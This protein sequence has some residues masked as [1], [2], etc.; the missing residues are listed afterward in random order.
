[1]FLSTLVRR[2]EDLPDKEAVLREA[3]RQLQ[4]W[5]GVESSVLRLVE[6]QDTSMRVGFTENDREWICR[7]RVADKQLEFRHPN[8]PLLSPTDKEG[9]E[10]FAEFLEDI[11]LG[12]QLQEFQQKKTLLLLC[13]CVWVRDVIRA[14]IICFNFCTYTS[15]F[16]P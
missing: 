11:L 3:V 12:V 16:L 8:P 13:I 9:L 15:R 6:Q 10:G 1:M 5:L 4:D 14:I 7:I 2:L